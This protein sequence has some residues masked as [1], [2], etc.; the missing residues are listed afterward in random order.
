MG[1]VGFPMA[2]DHRVRH[3]LRAVYLS[4]EGTTR[5]SRV[6]C[7]TNGYQRSSVQVLEGQVSV[8]CPMLFLVLVRVQVHAYPA[9]SSFQAVKGAFS[10]KPA[11]KLG[12]PSYS[13]VTHIPLQLPCRG[14]LDENSR[15]WDFCP[16]LGAPGQ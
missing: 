10:G 13:S 5:I 4:H 1:N 11:L 2:R 12:R 6:H 8:P 16:N 14:V 3:D 7:P 9:S 15:P